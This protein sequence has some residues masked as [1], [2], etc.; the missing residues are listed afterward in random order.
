VA[1]KRGVAKTETVARPAAKK[2]GVAK[3][4]PVVNPTAAVVNPVSAVPKRRG[5]PKSSTEAPKGNVLSIRG[6]E[7]WRDWVGRLA[8]HGRLKVADVI[9]RAL[10]L[11][12]KHEGFDEP[13]PRR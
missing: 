7:E 6:S 12:A 4:E 11:Y 9:D 1:K 8:D 2:R 10:L 5:R 3:T 13:A